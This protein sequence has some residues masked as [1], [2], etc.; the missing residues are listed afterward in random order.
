M[1]KIKTTGFWIS[2]SG[3]IVL[4][5]QTV[6]EIFGFTINSQIVST[7]ISSI[8]SVLVVVGILIPTSVEDLK[9]NIPGVDITENNS[10]LNQTKSVKNY[11]DCLELK[12]S[13]DSK[14]V[15]FEKDVD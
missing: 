15:E 6:G 10:E 2:L 13:T 14:V 5:L 9:L 7:L 12:N 1:N 4:V 11:E 3:A 8:C